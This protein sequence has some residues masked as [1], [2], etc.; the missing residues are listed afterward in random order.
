M[1]ALAWPPTLRRVASPFSLTRA[2]PDCSALP[3]ATRR[4]LPRLTWVGLGWRRDVT[5]A[6]E[7]QHD[8][9]LRPLPG[10]WDLY[11]AVPTPSCPS[12]ETSGKLE[13]LPEGAP[14]P[15]KKAKD[16]PQTSPAPGP[17]LCRRLPVP[18]SYCP[19]R[20]PGLRGAGSPHGDQRVLQSA[21]LLPPPGSLH[22]LAHS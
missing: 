17:S 7:P 19:P 8:S 12:R 13:T 10:S 6:L 11:M 21:R 16:L 22:K 18:G 15:P 2:P 4:R 14:A 20:R 3:R 9:A 5:L 1:Q